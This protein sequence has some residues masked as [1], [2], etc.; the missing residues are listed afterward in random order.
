M[1]LYESVKNISEMT[2]NMISEKLQERAINEQNKEQTIESSSK[3]ELMK[4]VYV[5]GSVN[6]IE[7]ST[8][9]EETTKKIMLFLREKGLSENLIKTL[10]DA[11]LTNEYIRL[12]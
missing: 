3:H 10:I 11:N 6:N 5:I 9:E 8:E 7:K 4:D 1:S 2:D 12:V